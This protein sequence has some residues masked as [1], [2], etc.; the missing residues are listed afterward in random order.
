MKK[1]STNKVFPISAE[2]K[3]LVNMESNIAFQKTKFNIPNDFYF[4]TC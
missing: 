3:F 1:K 2:F 4:P